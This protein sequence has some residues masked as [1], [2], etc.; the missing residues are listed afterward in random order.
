MFCRDCEHCIV[1]HESE[2]CGRFP[3]VLELPETVYC[4]AFEEKEAVDE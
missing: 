3:E 4:V 2:F 1:G